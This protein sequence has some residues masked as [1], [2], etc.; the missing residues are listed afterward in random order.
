MSEPRVSVVVPAPRLTELGRRCLARVLEL[1][2]PVEVVFVP[3]EAP[4]EALDPRILCVPSGPALLGRK[5]QLGLERA[6]GEIVAFIDDDAYPHPDWLRNAVAALDADPGVAATTG[7]AVTPPDDPERAWLGGRVYASPL[8]SGPER[9]RH[10]PVAARDVPEAHGVNFVIRRRDALAIGLDT[11]DMP[12][13][14]TV[15]GDRLRARGRRI[16]YVPGAVLFHSRREL[17]RP[18]LFQL[19]RYARQ[20]ARFFRQ[21]GVSRRAAYAAP[22][23]LLLWLGLGWL[24]PRP[25]RRL[26]RASVVAY[27]AAC[28]V[29]GA[30]PRP[31]RWLRTSGAIAATHGVYG[32]SFLLG[33]LGVPL[34]E[35]RRRADR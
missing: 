10:L 31:G 35:W 18:H 12:G 22:S 24:A 14:D 34:Q 1:D 30:D 15:L 33:L 8:V 5:R 6:R 28:A 29:A 16:R 13:D 32:L 11:P 20:R 26:W 27:A 9:W 21:G 2:P 19:W 17:W 25:L 3:D 4:D 7:P 23:A